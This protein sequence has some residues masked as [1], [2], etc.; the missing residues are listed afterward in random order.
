MAFLLPI[1][2]NHCFLPSHTISY[3]VAK[4]KYSL[5][6]SS[7]SSSTCC[8]HSDDEVYAMYQN[9]KQNNTWKIFCTQLPAYND[10]DSY[11]FY[12]SNRFFGSQLPKTIMAFKRDICDRRFL[13]SALH[14]FRTAA[15]ATKRKRSRFEIYYR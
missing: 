10:S 12:L 3:D 2:T 14:E 11:Y 1:R 9:N 5:F 8:C 6:S 7:I 13:M 4:I 15:L